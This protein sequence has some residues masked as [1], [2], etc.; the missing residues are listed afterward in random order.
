MA[1]FLLGMWMGCSVLIGLIALEDSHLAGAAGGALLAEQDWRHFYS[2]EEVQIGLGLV[3]A[4]CLF[5]GT[6]RRITPLICCGAMLL[7]V[8]FEHSSLTPDLIVDQAERAKPL[9]N[10]RIATA[11]T[12]PLNLSRIYGVAEGVKFLIGGFLA[13]YLFV[14]RTRQRVRKTAGEAVSI[15]RG[16][17]ELHR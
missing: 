17:S 9:T 1:T 5:L 11:R 12:H 16:P 8:L 10:D 13:S 2:W 7:L 4:I 14:F 3:L 6:Q 15:R